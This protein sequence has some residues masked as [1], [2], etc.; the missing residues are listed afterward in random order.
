MMEI[1]LRCFHDA[2]KLGDMKAYDMKPDSLTEFNCISWICPECK[3]EVLMVW[4][5]ESKGANDGKKKE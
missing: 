5:L 1:I 3:R 2:E 4:N